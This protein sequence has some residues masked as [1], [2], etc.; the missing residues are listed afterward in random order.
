[1]S[2]TKGQL[3]EP[4]GQNIVENFTINSREVMNSKIWEEFD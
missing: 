1:M 4:Y 3:V 2:F